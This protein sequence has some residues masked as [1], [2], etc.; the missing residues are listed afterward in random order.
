MKEAMIE[1]CECIRRGCMLNSARENLLE[2]FA[3]RPDTITSS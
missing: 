2:I 1:G 3:V